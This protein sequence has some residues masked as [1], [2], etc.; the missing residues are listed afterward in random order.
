MTDLWLYNKIKDLEN[1]GSGSAEDNVGQLDTFFTHVQ[2]YNQYSSYNY[3]DNSIRPDQ[4]AGANIIGLNAIRFGQGATNHRY[5]RHMMMPTIQSANV[6]NSYT[7]QVYY[8]RSYRRGW[9]SSNEYS[10]P[11]H[12]IRVW[13]IENT[14]DA[15]VSYNQTYRQS[16]YST[17]SGWGYYA[18]NPNTLTNDKYTNFTTTLI[19]GGTNGEHSQERTI[20]TTIPANSVTMFMLITSDYY[21]GDTYSNNGKYFSHTNALV[22]LSSVFTDTALKPRNDFVK[23][24]MKGGLID[25]SSGGTHENGVYN[26]WNKLV[27]KQ[28]MQ[29]PAA[30]SHLE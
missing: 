2:R 4:V 26:L 9:T 18:I 7:D 6:M 20:A 5:D 16:S 11:A 25:A 28:D 13:A 23:E 24:I 21:I 17:Y 29:V 22:N 30:Y 3:Q 1:S 27:L 19:Q 12:G 15:S 10:Y 14:S 8:E